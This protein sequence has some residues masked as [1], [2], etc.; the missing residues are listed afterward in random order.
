MESATTL[1]YVLLAASPYALSWL[2][3]ELYAKRPG[4]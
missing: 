2:Y 4:A 3:L 1:L